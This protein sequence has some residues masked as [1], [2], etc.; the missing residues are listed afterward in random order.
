MKRSLIL[1]I[2]QD[3]IPKNRVGKGYTIRPMVQT[4]RK[5]KASKSACR[6]KVCTP[7]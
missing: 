1:T 5:K 4:D 7:L 6:K 3:D 2:K